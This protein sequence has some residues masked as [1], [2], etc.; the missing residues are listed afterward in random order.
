MQH[1]SGTS[2]L[3]Y[4]TSPQS[5]RA[6]PEAGF[7]PRVI[8]LVCE[9]GGGHH[10]AAR[11]LTAA[12]HQTYPDTYE[13]ETISVENLLGP[14]GKVMGETF[15]QSYN[16]ALRHGQ[17]W[18][19]PWIFG[20]LTASRKL[21]ESIGVGYLT[22]FLEAKRPDL[23]VT[24]IH[25]AHDAMVPA[26]QRYGGLPH[27]TVITDAV[28]IRSSWLHPGCDEFVVSTE[29]ARQSCLEQ[30][31]PAERLRHI[32]HP[33]DPRFAHPTETVQDLRRRFFIAPN[34]FTIMMMMGGT[35]GK[36]IL[37]FTRQLAEA[38]LPVQVIACCGTDKGLARRMQKYALKA[39]FPVKVFGYTTEIPNLMSLSNLIITKPGPG[40]I[41]EAMARDLPMIVDDTNYTMWQEKGNLDYV[42]KY[43][44]GRVIEKRQE[45]VPV[46]QEL[47]DNPAAYAAMKKAVG[48]HK[49]PDASLQ[50]AT[51][52][53]Q[54]L[55]SALEKR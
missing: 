22:R 21:C 20:A 9:A 47:L 19:E 35:G 39:P 23:L 26:I 30:G 42:R 37:R 5:L 11:A 13:T 1:S 6:L 48:Q 33:V 4:P 50:I 15:S 36:N 10:S 53:H 54:R 46:V 29:E 24:L 2:S 27:L 31:I 45:L 16:V 3:S 51:L 17:Y 49:C 25:G 18:L 41:M 7:K 55:S 12:L 8:F 52:I 43:N 40:T 32:G 28:S 14:V 38:N 34:R 44:L